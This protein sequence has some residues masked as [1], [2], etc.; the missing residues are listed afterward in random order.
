[1]LQS[2]H[3]MDGWAE[4]YWRRLLDFPVKIVC[5]AISLIVGNCSAGTCV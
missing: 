1:M 5:F 3:I 2:D 4:T